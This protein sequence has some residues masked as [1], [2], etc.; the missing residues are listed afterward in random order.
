VHR[1][2][3]AYGSAHSCA[4][5]TVPCCRQTGDFAH[6]TAS[7]ADVAH[8]RAAQRLLAVWLIY[9]PFAGNTLRVRPC[10]VTPWPYLQPIEPVADSHCCVTAGICRSTSLT[11]EVPAGP[12]TLVDLQSTTNTHKNLRLTSSPH[13]ICTISVSFQ[14]PRHPC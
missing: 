14:H 13:E 8:A 2:I 7:A 9:I 11:Q 10:P 12:G 3:V 4:C 1:C 6:A 5:R